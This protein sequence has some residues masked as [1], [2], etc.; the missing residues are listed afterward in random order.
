MFLNQLNQQQ[1]AAVTT[2]FQYVRIIAGAGTGKTRVLTYRI[3]YLVQELQIQSHH[4]LA[5]TFTNKV[6]KEMLDRTKQLLSGYEG[7]FFISTF[8]S[9]SARLLRE[10]IHHLGYPRHF[11]NL[12]DDEKEKLVKTIVL[13]P[14]YKK[15]DAINK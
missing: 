8:H 12:D 7:R 1:Q 15:G 5:I 9:F 6:A 4:I 13:E 3:A 11:T 14:A 10:D 2:D